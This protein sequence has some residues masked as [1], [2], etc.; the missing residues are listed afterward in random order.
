MCP[1]NVPYY[2]N[3][4]KNGCTYSDCIRHGSKREF[5]AEHDHS[6]YCPYFTLEKIDDQ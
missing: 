6:D 5:E 2:C 1:D 4:K 3:T